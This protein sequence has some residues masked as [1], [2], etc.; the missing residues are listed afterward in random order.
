[1]ISFGHTVNRNLKLLTYGSSIRCKATNAYAKTLNLPNSGKFN[2]SMKNIYENEQRIK[3]VFFL[4]STKYSSQARSV[5]KNR[6][7]C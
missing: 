2:L 7:G 5:K 6:R 3:E 4:V 1:M